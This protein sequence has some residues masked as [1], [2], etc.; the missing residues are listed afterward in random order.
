MFK[1]NNDQTKTEDAQYKGHSYRLS[2]KKIRDS[3]SIRL[4]ENE[5][6]VIGENTNNPT[7]R[8][9][10]ELEKPADQQILEWAQKVIEQGYGECDK[11][12]ESK[13]LL[14]LEDYDKE[15]EDFAGLNKICKN[16]RDLIYDKIFE[17]LR[18]EHEKD[19]DDLIKI[20]E[21][22]KPVIIGGFREKIVAYE[23]IL[24]IPNP[25]I[26]DLDDGFII[27]KAIL[28]ANDGSFYPV[29]CTIDR[30]SGGELWDSQF[31]SNDCDFC[32][33]QNLIF[34]YI[35]KSVD[36]IFPYTYETLPV[37][38]E[39]FHQSP[40]IGTVTRL[41]IKHH[42]SNLIRISNSENDNG[43]VSIRS[44]FSNQHL[45]SAAMFLVEIKEVENSLKKQFDDVVLLRQRALC[46]SVV[47][48]ATAYLEASINEL[49]IDSKDNRIGI[50]RDLSNEEIDALS[51]MWDIGVP[52]TANYSIIE[53]YQIALALLQ[54]EKIDL[55]CDPAQSV[56]LLVKLR[57]ALTHYEPEWVSTR[58]SEC[59]EDKQQRLEKL[60]SGRF[61]LNEF[62]GADNPFFP[63]KCLSYGM[64]AWAYKTVIDF[65]NLFFVRIGIIP[66]YE[67][68]RHKIAK[69][70]NG[71]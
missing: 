6:M 2:V 17:K 51:R 53:K 30:H 22:K 23:Y 47:L 41:P 40:W 16:C 10:V 71:N 36:D 7:F 13:F 50:V 46:I 1:W 60:L 35:N 14:L 38:E 52:R 4:F 58:S 3:Y 70:Q 45:L 67:K 65:I 5:Q 39:D 43:L 25:H 54:K 68:I 42:F 29:F 24:S 37:I 26:E 55:S 31:I 69:I 34:P 19:L 9:L 48:S 20:L 27:A 56:A 49:F 44:Y 33:P 8:E 21:E 57:N 62:T 59:G 64:A 28:K 15:K 11:C 61:Q 66:P 63:D 12:N 32:I 18:Q